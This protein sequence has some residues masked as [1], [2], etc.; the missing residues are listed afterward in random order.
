M[1]H[2]NKFEKAVFISSD[3]DFEPLIKELINQGKFL[4]LIVADIKTCSIILKRLAK[5]NIV[6]LDEIKHKI[7]KSAPKDKTFR[8][9]SSS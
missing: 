4:R 6:G 7:R 2:I 3:G 9:A 1:K 5:G 8:N